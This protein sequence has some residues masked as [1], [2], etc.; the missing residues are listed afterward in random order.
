[1]SNSSV[2]GIILA[3]GKGT[4][5]KS[6]Q[7]KGL[8]EVC[9]LPMV[10][11]VARALRDAGVQRIILVI[12]HGGE[13]LQAKLGDRYEYT[14]HIGSESRV[15]VSPAAREVKRGDRICLELKPEGVTLW[16]RE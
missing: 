2:A 7:P 4:R 6:E 9:G 10:E 11:H 14:V 12:G 15:L 16:P 13:A 3:A 1:M 5:M 8:H